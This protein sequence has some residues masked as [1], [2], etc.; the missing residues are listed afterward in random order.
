MHNCIFCCCCFVL[1]FLFVVVFLGIISGVHYGDALSD[2]FISKLHDKKLWCEDRRSG[3]VTLKVPSIV[4][5]TTWSD[6]HIKQAHKN[7]QHKKPPCY[8]GFTSSDQLEFLLRKHCILP[9]I[10]ENES[11]NRKKVEWYEAACKYLWGIPCNPNAF[12]FLDM[13]CTPQSSYV[14]L[15]QYLIYNYIRI[16]ILFIFF[17]FCC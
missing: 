4:T 13:F 16:Q 9:C 15:T 17:I 5:L 14:V 6:M 8:W 2:Y 1:V 3:E 11:F 10:I 12:F 7:K